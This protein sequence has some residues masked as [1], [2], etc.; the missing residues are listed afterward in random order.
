MTALRDSVHATSLADGDGIKLTDVC[1][2][3]QTIHGRRADN[4]EFAN[5]RQR[6][7]QRARDRCCGQREDV[8]VCTH[9][10]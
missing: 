2:D 9:L 1:A 10:L 4:A 7:L 6:Q 5:A 3:R 8:N